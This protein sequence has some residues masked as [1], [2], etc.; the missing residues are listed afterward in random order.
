MDA[1]EV[2]RKKDEDFDILT[3]DPQAYKKYDLPVAYSDT[4]FLH[5]HRYRFQ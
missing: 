1:A 5:F 2:E 4:C 3:Y